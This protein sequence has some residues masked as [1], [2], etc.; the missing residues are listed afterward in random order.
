M[1]D[2]PQHYLWPMGN[3]PNY[4]TEA[5][6][7]AK[8]ILATMPAAKIGVLY[9][10]DG[11]GKDYLIGLR[12][13]LGVDHAAMIIK[14]ASYE[15]SEPTVDSQVVTLQGSGADVLVIAAMPKAAAQ[16][17]RKVYDIGWMPARYLSYVSSSVAARRSRQVQRADHRCVRKGP[18]R[19]ALE[20]RPRLQS[21]DGVRGEIP[22]RHRPY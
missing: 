10:N 4:Q 11:V 2:D 18:D 9:Q 16:T 21:L 7:F 3:I 19:P 13:G 22:V 6:I 15:V 14:E 17:I 20:G 8:H 1:F 5:H 12:A